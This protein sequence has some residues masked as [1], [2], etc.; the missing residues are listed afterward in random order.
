[1]LL[2]P[3][4]GV[5]YDLALF[6][7]RFYED[8]LIE[9]KNIGHI[10][11][12]SIDEN[13]QK[14]LYAIEIGVYDLTKQKENSGNYSNKG[15]NMASVEDYNSAVQVPEYLLVPTFVD[16]SKKHFLSNKLLETNTSIDKKNNIKFKNVENERVKVVLEKT[17]RFYGLAFD[18]EQKIIQAGISANN[19]RVSQYGTL[20]A[21]VK[22]PNSNDDYLLSNW[23][24]FSNSGAKI[25]DEILHP[26][27]LDN[28][29]KGKNKIA[30]LV[31]FRLDSKIDV[32]LSKITSGIAIH[33]VSK[34]NYTIEGKTSPSVGM[35][36]KKCGRTTE[37]QQ[38]KI[39]DLHVSRWVEHPQYP[40]GKLFFK[41]QIEV[42]IMCRPGD[43]GSILVEDESGTNKAV[44]LI[45]A[46]DKKNTCLANELKFNNF[47]EAPIYEEIENSILNLDIIF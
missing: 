16:K 32:A 1:M 20:G 17:Q 14:K 30:E 29:R 36:I 23:H 11:I 13:D 42:L 39:T 40:N 6:V 19:Y 8:K 37:F 3:F 2:Q 7:K 31:W 27:P 44:G 33:N 10:K 46:G 18:E 47:Q 15:A 34:C 22:L 26:S 35:Q 38:G 25:G 12:V 43:S 21:I 28:G 41:E 5:S 24:V 4:E 9:N 45:F